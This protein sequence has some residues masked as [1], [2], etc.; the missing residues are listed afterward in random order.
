L[1]LPSN[2]SMKSRQNDRSLGLYLHDW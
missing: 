2:Y 1:V